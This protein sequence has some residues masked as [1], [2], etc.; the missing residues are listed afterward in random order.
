MQD[1]GINIKTSLGQSSNKLKEASDQFKKLSGNTRSAKSEYAKFGK[2]IQ[3]VNNKFTNLNKDMNRSNQ[4]FIRL[5]N[6][7]SKLTSV[8]NLGTMASYGMG[9]SL[10]NMVQ[11][12]LDM[13]E[14][15]NLFNVALGDTADSA[16]KTTNEMSKAFGLDTTNLENATGTYALLSRSM[17]MST[18]QAE[19]LSTTMVQLATDYASLTNVPVAQALADLKSGLVGQS[20]TVYKYGLDVT[21]AGIKA[22]AMTEGITKSVRNMTQGEKMALRYNAMLRQSKLTQGDFARTI[23]TP[24]NQ[25]KILSERFTTLGRTIGTIFI[26]IITKLVP[27]LNAFVTV[28]TNM[29][30]SIAKFFGYVKDL[31]GGNS[32]TTSGLDGIT[33][34]SEDATDSIDDTTTSVKKLKRAMMGFDQLNI[35]SNPEN[36]SSSSSGNDSTSIL[37]TF[38]LSTYDNLMGTVNQISNGIAE[39]IT[40]VFSKIQEYAK[41]TTESLKKL[42]NEG[43]KDLVN[44]EVKGLIDFYESFLKPIGIWTLGTGLPNLFNVINGFIKEINFKMLNSAFKELLEALE[45]FVEGIGNGLIDFF[46]AITDIGAIA[47]NTFA[48]A[49]KVFTTVL[50][51]LPASEWRNY[52]IVFGDLL[53]GLLMFKGLVVVAGSIDKFKIAFDGLML[54][55]TKHPILLIASALTTI[56]VAIYQIANQKTASDIDSTSESLKNLIGD[57]DTT[58]GKLKST[59]DELSA[60]YGATRGFADKYFELADNFSNLTDS[61]KTMLKTYAKFIVDEVPEL[62]SS[63]NTVTGEFTGQK[64]EVYKTIDSLEKYAK[65]LAM[66]DILKEL[67][68]EQ[69]QLAIS[70]KENRLQYNNARNEM[71][72]YLASMDKISIA[73][74]EE[75]IMGRDLN[76]I[77]E[78]YSDSMN[79]NGKE[80]KWTAKEIDTLND[81]QDSL[82]KATEKVTRSIGTATDYIVEMG[83]AVTTTSEQASNAVVNKFNALPS[84]LESA[85]SNA[86]NGFRNGFGGTDLVGFAQGQVNGIQN[87]F[88]GLNVGQFAFASAESW[89]NSFADAIEET[90]FQIEPTGGLAD[91][92]ASMLFGVKRKF[93]TGGIVNSATLFGNSLIGEAG[94]EAIVPLERNTEWIDNVASRLMQSQVGLTYYDAKNAFKDAIKESDFGDTSL[95]VDSQE[96]ARATNRGNKIINKR[97]KLTL[98]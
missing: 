2:E 30:S 70:T 62:A 33:D 3:K 78:A 93:A 38:D 89:R 23:N 55:F 25:L 32:N 90:K 86:G 48:L 80:V 12:A 71:V 94:K 77:Y 63:I 5:G 7:M 88:A 91:N 82:R 76:F 92:P 4:S 11:S 51:A 41:P 20:E 66:Q 65:Q 85:G 73:Q 45:P 1:L 34:S 13:I 84:F 58:I 43:L 28:L 50:S 15:T 44:F 14:T 67:Y 79:R 75:I 98:E 56:G 6:R 95:F 59:P 96:L 16:R 19:T 29:A 87:A 17:G 47:I 24:A 57:L 21:E 60:T 52:G 81:E 18:K 54:A 83:G 53:G 27:Y 22:E 74:E 10:A 69:M 40:S 37:P 8:F 64:E 35:I 72:S 36:D 26:P 68:K 9:A 46:N 31:S 97:Y 42:Y 61:Q 49:F 39:K